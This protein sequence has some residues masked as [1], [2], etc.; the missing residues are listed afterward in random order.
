MAET[1]SLCIDGFQFA[2]RR[3]LRELFHIVCDKINTDTPQKRN[4]K[5]LRHAR[6]VGQIAADVL[7]QPEIE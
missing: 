2:C 1:D 6:A 3:F 5:N 4:R 7:L